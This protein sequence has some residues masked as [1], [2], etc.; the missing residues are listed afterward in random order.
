MECFW[1]RRA[2]LRNCSS[3]GSFIFVTLLPEIFTHEIPVRLAEQGDTIQNGAPKI[4]IIALKNDAVIVGKGE[5]G[6]A[7]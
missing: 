1:G 5:L 3:S 7:I 6:A 2:F 4:K